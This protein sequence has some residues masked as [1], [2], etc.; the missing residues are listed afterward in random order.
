M[1]TSIHTHAV[2]YWTNAARQQTRLIVQLRRQYMG[3]RGTVRGA[4]IDSVVNAKRRR[5]VFM[6]EARR[7]N[8][9]VA[10]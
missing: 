4:L 2:R 1:T 9:G 3:E 5:E 6:A 10:A 8:V 7:L